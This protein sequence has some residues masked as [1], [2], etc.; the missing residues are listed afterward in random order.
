LQILHDDDDEDKDD[1]LQC[2]T[3]AIPCFIG[4]DVHD[5]LYS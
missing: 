3:H 5:G 4:C 2:S 1:V